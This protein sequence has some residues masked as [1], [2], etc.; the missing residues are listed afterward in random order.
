MNFFSYL[1]ARLLMLSMF[2]LAIL[3]IACAL[4]LDAT[5]SLFTVQYTI[6]C[7]VLI[8]CVSVLTDYILMSKRFLMLRKLLKQDSDPVK[9]PIPVDPIEDQYQKLLMH[10]IQRNTEKLFSAREAAAENAEFMSAWVHEVKTPITALHL[11]LDQGEVSEQSM[12]SIAEEVDRIDSFVEKVLFH[13]RSDAFAQDYLLAEEDLHQLM[14]NCIKRHANL[15]IHKGIHLVDQIDEGMFVYTDRKWL[16]FILDQLLSNAL[17][18][19]PP[20]GKITLSVL[21]DDKQTVLQIADTGCGIKS[22][23]LP[24]LFRKSFTG[25]NGRQGVKSTGFG[26]Y[27]SKKL[28]DKLGHQLKLES[29]W[30][31][32][33]VASVVFH[34][35]H[36]YY[37]PD[38]DNRDVTKL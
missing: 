4:L 12:A 33:S 15:F 32:G 24:R 26:L 2:I 28:S 11:L 20:G 14:R 8:M 21:K 37:Q 6:F 38:I 36:D 13:A 9:L 30:E 7:G 17:K 31:K 5:A 27:L 34:A 35:W 22:E 19:T 18:Y 1:R 10:S 25:Y 23:D 29:I 3:L 16:S